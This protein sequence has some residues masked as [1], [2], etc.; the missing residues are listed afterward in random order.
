MTIAESNYPVAENLDRIIAKKGLKKIFVAEKAGI[1]GPGLSDIL[2]GR[3]LIKPTDIRN[4]ASVLD[5]GVDELF[6][7]PKEA[8]NENAE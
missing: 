4:F 1:D 7:D 5:I 8:E 6:K 2:G 3:K